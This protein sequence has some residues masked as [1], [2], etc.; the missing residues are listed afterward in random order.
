[1][2]GW[3][4]WLGGA[5]DFFTQG[6]GGGVNDITGVTGQNNFSAAQ[7]AQQ[8]AW[9]RQNMQ[10]AR[11]WA[12]TDYTRMLEDQTRLANTA[13]QREVADLRAAGLNPILSGT[14]GSGAASPMVTHAATGAMSGGGAGGGGTS[15]GGGS[16][17]SLLGQAT[18]FFN[19]AKDRQL[20][21]QQAHNVEQDTWKKTY[22]TGMAQRDMGVKNST[23]DSERKAINAMNEAK[24]TEAERDKAYAE[25]DMKHIDFNYWLNKAPD[26]TNSA[27][28]ATEALGNIKKILMGF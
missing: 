4:G 10:Q 9:T 2:G 19:S 15:G 18:N 8:Q 26:I 14:G 17:A 7:S 6:M 28:G 27:K 16:F 25:K 3:G 22:E 24:R 13:H 23:L 21:E 20:M 11:D 5:M 12:D 1:M